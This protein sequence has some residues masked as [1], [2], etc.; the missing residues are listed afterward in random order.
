MSLR[1]SANELEVKIRQAVPILC[2]YGYVTFV[3][4]KGHLLSQDV[5]GPTYKFHAGH[6]PKPLCV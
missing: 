1:C 3:S 5:F 4:D 6:V 2:R